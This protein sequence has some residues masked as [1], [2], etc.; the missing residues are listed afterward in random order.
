MLSEVEEAAEKAA[1][2]PVG[3][4]LGDERWSPSMMEQGV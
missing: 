4:T 1:G 2:R 3:I